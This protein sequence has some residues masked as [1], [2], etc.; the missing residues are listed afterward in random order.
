[1]LESTSA[2]ENTFERLQSLLLEPQMSELRQQNQSLDQQVDI[3]EQQLSRLTYQLS[4]PTALMELMQPV[5]A[6]LLR[7]GVTE[8]RDLFSALVAELIDVAFTA[9]IQQDRE[10]MAT[11]L[12]PIIP[13][14]IAYSSKTTP[15]AMGQAIAPNLSR[16][17]KE[18]IEQDRGAIAQA[19]APEMG[20]ALKEQIRLE[21]DAVVDAL[22]P[23]IGNTIS[24][25]FAE[26]LKEINDKLEQAL[27]F[28]T[29]TRKLR[30]RLGG[31]SEAELLLRESTPVRVQAVFLIHKTSG[32]VISE[33]QPANSAPLESELIAGMLTAIRN[34]VREYV[35]QS[36]SLSEL[37]EIEYGTAQIW[38]EEAG[39]CY[40]A[41]VIQGTPS[42]VFLHGAQGILSQLVNDHGERLQHFDGDLAAV[43]TAIP[44]RLQ[45]LIEEAQTSQGKPAS[46]TRSP[47]LLILLASF[48]IAVCLG[49]G[50]YWGYQR[51]QH[52]QLTNAL[53]H[54]LSQDPALALYRLEVHR[55]RQQ[56]VL[57]GYVPTDTLA[58][59]AV[60]LVASQAKS[61][62]LD[63][64][65]VVIQ[66]TRLS[67]L[68]VPSPDEIAANVQRTAKWFNQME[69]VSLSVEVQGDTATIE[70]TVNT[71][72][73]IKSINQAFRQIPGIQSIHHTTRV[74]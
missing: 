33:A 3:L 40:L 48:A 45:Q 4:E 51:Y 7:L 2:G 55:E 1:M 72:S 15:E 50:A 16:A 29:F 12:A 20:A 54:H 28:E 71:S 13:D 57:K 6:E 74:R 10:A 46:S 21:R 43:P 22:Y 26:L 73:Q 62:P 31:I 9:K 64:Q 19:I 37:R 63:N 52:T 25:Y 32:L 38:L 24:R 30:A 66:P 70:S 27:S 67:S 47:Q 11:A 35:S 39:Y 42:K 8:S 59:R 53:N 23:V 44:E 5:M 36:E 65:V 61:L 56:L 69:G 60:G 14:S 18:H 68:I 49:L 17:L 34:F 41:M 58:E